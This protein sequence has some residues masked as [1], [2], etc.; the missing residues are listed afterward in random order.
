MKNKVL[1]I[2]AII[3]MLTIIPITIFA[4]N[5]I[6][7]DLSVGNTNAAKSSMDVTKNLLGVLQAV[8][9]VTSVVALVIIGIRYMIS[10]VEQR[11]QLKGVMSHYVIGC[12]L[13]FATSNIVGLSYTIIEGMSPNHSWSTVIVDATC[14]TAGYVQKTCTKC[15]KV[16]KDIIPAT[17]HNYG[18]WVTTAA[19]C[20]TDGNNTRI[21]SKCKGADIQTIE[22]LGH[23]YGDWTTKIAAK[24]TLNG[25]KQRKCSR[26]DSIDT[27]STAA[28][29]HSY[30][31]WTIKLAATCTLDG[32]KQRKCSTC[33]NI[34]T[35]TIAKTGHN[36]GDWTTTTAATCTTN[37]TK[38]STCS[39]CNAASTQSI[40]ATGHSYGEWV[41]HS[42]AT[43]T[44]PALQKRS[45]N[46]C[47]GGVQSQNSGS[48]LGHNWKISFTVA[49]YTWWKCE[50]CNIESDD[51]WIVEP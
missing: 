38:Q 26:C 13:V 16:L 48:A 47:G 44:Q 28:L 5:G 31:S 40:P 49:L 24:C 3:I 6:G 46:K 41:I 15:S 10:S 17:G 11:A 29:G 25:T 43:C 51:W 35:K 37:G 8:G 7:T 9:S 39:T 2:L 12:V 30:G 33:N 14:T 4:Y 36:Y 45:C 23:N 34:E 19:T 22:K 1:K 50:R 32:S 20:T 27:Q 42:V 21:C 18:G